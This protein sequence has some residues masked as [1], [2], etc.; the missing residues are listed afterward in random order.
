[1]NKAYRMVWSKARSAYVVTHEKS[2]SRGRPSTSCVAM[3]AG[4]VAMLLAAAPALSAN[5]CAGG[6]NTINTVQT[7]GDTCSLSNGAGLLVN[8]GGGLSNTGAPTV[9]GTGTSG[10]II[11]EGSIGTDFRVAIKLNS[12]QINGDIINRGAINSVSDGTIKDNGAIYATGAAITG[13]LINDGGTSNNQFDLQQSS[14]TS[15]KNINGGA[16]NVAGTQVSGIRLANSNV[17]DGIINDATSSITT[18]GYQTIG[19]YSTTVGTGGIVN[20]GQLNNGAISISNN[21][22]IQ[23]S[24]INTASGK[25]KDVQ[26]T[27]GIYLGSSS[28]IMGMIKNDGNISNSRFGFVAGDSTING[29]IVNSGLIQA[30]EFGIYLTGSSKVSTTN[31]GISNTGVLS[32]IYYGIAIEKSTL[33]G[34]L[35]AGQR[36]YA[37]YNSNQILATS[38]QNSTTSAISLGRGANINGDIINDT[39]GIIGGGS[40][41][42]NVTGA[43]KLNGTV[44]NSGNINGSRYAINVSDDSTLTD[45]LAIGNSTRF[46]GDV[47][48]KNSNFTVT[49]GSTFANDNAYNVKRFL[50]ERGSTMTLKNGASKSGMAAGIT[51]GSGGFVNAGAVRVDAGTTAAIHGDVDQAGTGT[52]TISDLRNT[53]A[54]KLTVDGVFNNRGDVGVYGNSILSAASINNNGRV[55]MS[56]TTSIKTVSGFSNN[57]AISVN[58]GAVAG[59]SGSFTQTATGSLTIGS[60]TGSATSLTSDNTITNGGSV[61][62]GKNASLTAAALSNNASVSMNNGS[63]ITTRNGF[64]NNGAVT[65]DAGTNASLSGSFT[66]TAS[67]S[68]TIGSNAGTATS[69]TSDGA[70]INGGAIALGN[71]AN[72]SATTVTNNA[73]VTMSNA[74]KITASNGFTNNGT[75]TLGTGVNASVAGN[76][77]QSA[78]G[79]LN[80]A[81]TDDT[82]YAKL[83]VTGTVT[84]SSNA[85]INVDVTQRDYQFTSKRLKNIVTAGQLVSDGSF[86]V[87]S[88]S[89]LF[90]FGAV[91]EGN[92][93]HL[94]LDTEAKTGGP[95]VLGS[96]IEQGNKN[97]MGAASALDRIIGRSPTGDIA[98]KFVSM[99]N[100]QSVSQAV[101]QTLPLL[102]GGSMAA[103]SGSVSSINRVVQ[104]RIESNRG[105][106]SGDEFLGDK[107]LWMKPFTSWAKQNDSDGVAG[108][109]ANTS[110]FV[111]GVD[112]T[113]NGTLRLGAGIAYASSKVN[114]NS[115]MAPQTMNVDVFQLL[116]YGS[117]SL[118]ER[119][120]INFQADIGQNNNQGTRTIAFTNST[121]SAKYKSLSAHAGVGVGRIFA[122]NESTNFTPSL[123]LDYA[124]IRDQAYAEKGADALNLNVNGRST[125]ELTAGIDGKLAHVINDKTTLTA[126]LGVGYDLIN[127]K[128]AIVAAYAGAADVAFATYGMEKS[129]WS[130]RAGLGA[131][132]KIINGTEL[133]AR[134]DAEGRSGFI[135]QTVSVKARWAF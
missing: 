58:D 114:G 24:V 102:S 133:S 43:S 93:V 128:S 23:G 124:W 107:Y 59:L 109:N 65:L 41:G 27:G 82:T 98:N 1:M 16:I 33:N 67:G 60:N 4:T 21:S 8:A 100:K 57:A 15:V 104:A 89:L 28:T 108:F 30:T 88:N 29:G 75:L 77:T 80:V 38:S 66:Q 54:T 130:M 56:D 96:A 48:A 135:N 110:G 115:S 87:K 52:L 94:T 76:Y 18:S 105:L 37:I 73:A 106:S 72:L 34:T 134:Y 10:S 14:M 131:S 35:N 125:R 74:A 49:A 32:G 90:K 7:T 63:T 111:L 5:I 117:Y 101:T 132:H 19:L 119:T 31:N 26:S 83:A 22:L 91:K 123:R 25:I 53:Q 11:N 129:P 13:A 99:T 42:I 127:D 113:A 47:Y 50:V 44:Y 40:N 79:A 68:L 9:S 112:G 45:I 95:T 116:G 69:L 122:L 62:I 3:A 46:V 120:E 86:Q 92:A 97:G 36:N 126:N 78:Q 103:A 121:A 64:T 2:S 51:V 17:T 39:G 12:V 61:V 118:D 70:I 71:N 85:K 55:V 20:Q 81:V 6:V 84:L